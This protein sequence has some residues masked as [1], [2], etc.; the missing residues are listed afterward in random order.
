MALPAW[1]ISAIATAAGAVLQKAFDDSVPAQFF[2]TAIDQAMNSFSKS[3]QARKMRKH[4]FDS[5]GP[6]S[7]HRGVYQGSIQ[8]LTPQV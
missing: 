7:Q 4:A 2:G 5:L 8:R 3:S 6:V 1:A